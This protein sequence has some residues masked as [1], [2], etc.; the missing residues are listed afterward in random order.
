MVKSLDLQV[1]KQIGVD[2]VSLVS[3]AGIWLTEDG[4]NSHVFHQDV[5]MPATNHISFSSEQI[6]KHPGSGKRIQSAAYLSDAFAQDHQVMQAM[7]GNICSNAISPR[8]GTASLPVVCGW[9]LSFS[10]SQP[11]HFDERLF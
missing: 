9:G 11:P 4:A 1:S 3:P 5:H 6:P 2:L 7:A 8:Y 10:P